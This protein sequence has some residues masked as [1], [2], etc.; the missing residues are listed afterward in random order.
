MSLNEKM[1][2]ARERPMKRGD[3]IRTLRNMIIWR[4]RRL[5]SSSCSE[6]AT[7]H[8]VGEIRALERALLALAGERQDDP[9]GRAWKRTL[10][11]LETADR[12]ETVV[13]DRREES[14]EDDD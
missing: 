12:G 11:A 1:R 9:E 8:L 10:D 14:E 6:G 13:D 5:A 7:G 2:Q 3:A 4:E